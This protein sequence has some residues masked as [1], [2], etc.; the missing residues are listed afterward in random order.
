MD[1]RKEF[2][3]NINFNSLDSEGGDLVSEFNPRPYKL[4]IHP[5]ARWETMSDK[6]TWKAP[7]FVD[8]DPKLI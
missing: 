3:S 5:T 2:I 4:I 1:P 8:D 7:G 6:R